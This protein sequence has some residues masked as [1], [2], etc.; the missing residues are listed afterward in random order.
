VPADSLEAIQAADAWAR[1]TARDLIK[2]FAR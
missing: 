2:R 1:R